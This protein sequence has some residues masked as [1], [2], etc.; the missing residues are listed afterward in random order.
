ME[1]VTFKKL[2]KGIL[3]VQTFSHQK[4]FLN[5]GEKVHKGCETNNGTQLETDGTQLETEM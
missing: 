5:P 4:H 3:Y 2:I 1:N